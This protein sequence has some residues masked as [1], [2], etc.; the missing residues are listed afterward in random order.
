MQRRALL[1]SAFAA[2]LAGCGFELRKPPTLRFGT[3][4]LKGF[5]PHSPLQEELTAAL[6]GTPSTRVVEAATQAQVILDVLADT[7]NT[8]VVASTAS[9]QV[10]DLTLVA[11]LAFRLETAGGRELIPVT[12]ILQSRDL[13]YNETVA[14]AKEQEASVLFKSMQTD[15][16][17]QLMRRL[18][19]VQL[20]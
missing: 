18:A 7:R 6:N 19:A 2:T 20:V 16:V 1:L 3:I 10:R 11:R 4:Q 9:G 5:R 17:S 8:A 12:E 13:T 15:I 14:L